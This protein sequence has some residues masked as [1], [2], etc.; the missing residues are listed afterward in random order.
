MAE[1]LDIRNIASPQTLAKNISITPKS[2]TEKKLAVI[3]SPIL[4][5][6]FFPMIATK[7]KMS[8]RKPNVSSAK[9]LNLPKIRK[10]KQIASRVYRYKVNIYILLFIY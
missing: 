1:I 4:E 10:N 5:D 3:R 6:S 7:A 9:E 8:P 2:P